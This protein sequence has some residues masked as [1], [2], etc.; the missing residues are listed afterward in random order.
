MQPSK[1]DHF[2][3]S[4]LKIK[5]ALMV[6]LVFFPDRSLCSLPH[7]VFHFLFRSSSLGSQSSNSLFDFFGDRPG[8]FGAKE[9]VGRGVKKCLL[10][11][12]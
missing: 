10:A 3:S 2:I 12:A 1:K 5:C 4:N 6:C 7:G 11:G 9:V 8:S